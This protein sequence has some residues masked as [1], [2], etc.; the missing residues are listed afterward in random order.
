MTQSSDL[1]LG[2]THRAKIVLV[3]D[4]RADQF[5]ILE[6]LRRNVAEFEAE[7]IGDAPKAKK[8]LTDIERN[9]LESAPDLFLIDLNLPGGWGG[10]IAEQI[11]GSSRFPDA[12]VVIMSSSRRP[13]DVD[14][15][16]SLRCSYFHKAQGLDAFFKIGSLARDLLHVSGAAS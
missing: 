4:S 11:R 16:R 10:A 13:S 6:A 1:R 12:A 9:P 7:V 15:A 8:R 3:E 5:M 14:M 2:E